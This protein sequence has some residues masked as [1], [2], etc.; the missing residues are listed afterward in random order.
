MTEMEM[1]TRP[2]PVYL[3]RHSIDHAVGETS[4][5]SAS[6]SIVLTGH[7]YDVDRVYYATDQR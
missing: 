7:V 1:E 4:G 5:T 6:G 2:G 3:G